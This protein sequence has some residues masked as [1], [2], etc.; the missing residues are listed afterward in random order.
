MLEAGIVLIAV[1]FF[2]VSRIASVLNEVNKDL[3][4]IAKQIER[5]HERIDKLSSK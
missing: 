1:L 3:E 4:K 5:L 2:W